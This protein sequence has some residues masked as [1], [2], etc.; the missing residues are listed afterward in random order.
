MLP[1]GGG[2]H[3]LGAKSTAGGRGSQPPCPRL[4]PRRCDDWEA[5]AG[6][7]LTVRQSILGSHQEGPKLQEDLWSF[8]LSL[9]GGVKSFP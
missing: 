8:F 4:L 5:E 2:E 6:W 7:S 1:P 9:L 3:L